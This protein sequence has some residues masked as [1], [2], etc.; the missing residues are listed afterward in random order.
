MKKIIIKS[1]GADWVLGQINIELN[2]LLSQNFKFKKFNFIN[3]LLTREIFFLSKYDF[4]RIPTFIFKKIFLCIFHIENDILI[5][6]KIINKIKKNEKKINIIISNTR[7]KKIL[8]QNGINPSR[9]KLIHI[10]FFK[11]YFYQIKKNKTIKLKEKLG[12]KNFK[13]IGSFQKDGNGWGLGSTPKIIKDPDTFIESVNILSRKYKIIVILSGPSRG[14]VINQFDALGIKYIY[15]KNLKFHNLNKLYN[16]IDLY[17]ISSLEEGGPRAVLESMATGT[18]VI[19]TKVGQAVDIIK[20]G[21]NGFLVEKQNPNLIAEISSHLFENQN[22]YN[23][24]SYNSLNSSSK[25]EYYNL[26]ND[27][28][29]VLTK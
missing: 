18:P 3:L 14:Y 8:I 16:L 1:D 20:D 11:K 17:I 26:K 28:I 25:Y 6:S 7:V 9:I 19:S 23:K 12:L 22:I 10:S 13:I 29:N 15:F 27:W 21:Q 24:V 4:I 5:M 2:H